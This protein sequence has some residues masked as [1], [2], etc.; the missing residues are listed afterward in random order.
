[1]GLTPEDIKLLP[2][3]VRRCIQGIDYNEREFIDKQGNKVVERK[4]KLRLVD[5]LRAIDMIN[6]HLDFYNAD[7]QSK[8]QTIDISKATPDQ[9]NVVLG[10]LES[11]ISND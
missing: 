2:P 6:K 9:L 4:I 10:L 3:E 1:L 11:Q 7:N 8:K 5:K